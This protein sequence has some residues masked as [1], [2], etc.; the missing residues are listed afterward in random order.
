M[1][2]LKLDVS[3]MQDDFFADA[4][5]IGIIICVMSYT[6][7]CIVTGNLISNLRA[8]RN[9]PFPA[10]KKIRSSI[11]RYTNTSFRTAVTNICYTN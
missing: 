4:A 11:F 2:K 9:K 1:A 10:A 3:A 7:L 6:S 8:T 5:I